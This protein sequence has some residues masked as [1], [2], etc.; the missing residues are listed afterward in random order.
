MFYKTIKLISMFSRMHSINLINKDAWLPFVNMMHAFRLYLITKK[1]NLCQN[2]R[3]SLSSLSREY[4]F[5]C[6]GVGGGGCLVIFLMPH[7]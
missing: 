2:N 3:H 5:L 1:L 4:N 6:R 7:I